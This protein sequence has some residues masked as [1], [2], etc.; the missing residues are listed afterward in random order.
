LKN[1]LEILPV[2][3]D[4][5]NCTLICEVSNEGFSYAIKDDETNTYIGVSVSHFNKSHRTD[6]YSSNFENGLQH[7][8]LL[9][10]NFKKVYIIYSFEE[11]VLIPFPLYDSQQSGNA[12]NLI[13]GDLQNNTSVLTDVIAEKGIYNSYRISTPLL[14]TTRSKFPEAIN[15]HQYSVL[16][17]QLSTGADRLSVIFY[18]KKIVLTLIKNGVAQFINTFEYK[19][20]EEVLY[21]LLNTCKQFN[22][23]NIPL[24]ISGMIEMNSALS[25]EIYKYFNYVS[26][27]ALP[28]ECNY[29]EEIINHPSHYFSH[30]FAVDS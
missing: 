21:V 9:S 15:R 28:A 3:I 2:S 26:F 17:K 19:T 11:S 6:D 22:A 16:L 24:E 23:E 18:S 1:V 25:K 13:H 27:T 5:Q 29:S 7:Q 30:I 10:G 12:L 4:A 8:S 14:V 20:A